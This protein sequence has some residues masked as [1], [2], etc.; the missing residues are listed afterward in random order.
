MRKMEI[1]VYR[2]SK[3]IVE[4]EIDTL[5]VAK[6]S[7]LGIGA[8]NIINHL[9]L[10]LVFTHKKFILDLLE[11]PSILDLELKEIIYIIEQLKFM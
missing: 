10:I 8:F 1:T 2:D 9:P 7:V 6:Y 11:V 4:T 3:K 5:K